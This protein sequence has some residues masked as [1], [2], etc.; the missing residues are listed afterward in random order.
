MTDFIKTIDAEAPALYVLELDSQFLEDQSVQTCFAV[1]V[2]A[3]AEG[4]LIAIPPGYVSTQVLED[5]MTAPVT[6]LIGPSLEIQVVGVEEETDGS[7]ML[8]GVDLRAVLVDFNISVRPY[9]RE[10]DDQ[11]EGVP[12]LVFFT[13]SPSVLPSSQSLMN[14]ALEWIGRDGPLSE[15]V[16][17]YSA[18]EEPLQS[19]LQTARPKPGAK[20]KG[21]AQTSGPKKVTTAQLADQFASL[22][23]SIP[24]I[25]SQLEMLKGQQNQLQMSLQGSQVPKPP[26]YRQPFPQAQNPEGGGAS[27]QMFGGLVGTPPR[28]KLPTKV[29]LSPAAQAL[30]EDEPL[31]VP[32]EEGFLKS[33]AP[34]VQADIPNALLQQSQAISALVAH[35]IGQDSLTDLASS[36]GSSSLST[37]GTAKREKLQS[38]LANR[39]GNFLLQVAQ[40]AHRRL[41]P[42]EPVPKDF[43]SFNG[44]SILSKY[45][46]RQGGFQGQKDLGLV[47]W[48]LAQ[49]GDL[50]IAGDQRGAS[51]MLALALV[52]V[53]QCAQDQGRWELAWILQEFSLRGRLLPIDG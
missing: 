11:S 30:P 3:R 22:M 9:L 15:R 12:G 10:F 6:D 25:Q 44:K 5:G 24:A 37:K 31:F 7:E 40:N 18:T 33:M 28:T 51:E 47:A 52:T 14:Q 21:K 46:E 53:E 26:P 35:L 39:S 43:P 29:G 17:Y 45:L 16:Q 34:P 50:M 38:D 19:P 27:I 41:K 13:E 20:A 36:G 2:L 1:P 4:L 23:Q 42:T 8:L 32:S 49:I 48:L